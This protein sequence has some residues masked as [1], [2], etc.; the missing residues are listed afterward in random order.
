MIRTIIRRLR[1]K[2]GQ[3]PS[4]KHRQSI[5]EASTAVLIA[6]RAMRASNRRADVAAA[7][8]AKH[9]ILARGR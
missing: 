9:L 6:R 1:E 8:E 4:T 5:D 7:Y 3:L 2:R